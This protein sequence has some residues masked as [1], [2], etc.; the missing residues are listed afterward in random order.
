LKKKSGSSSRRKVGIFPYV[1]VIL[2]GLTVFAVGFCTALG[3][4]GNL[5]D[6]LKVLFSQTFQDEKGNKKPQKKQKKEK[7]KQGLIARSESEEKTGEAAVPE[8]IKP[9]KNIDPKQELVPEN[10]ESPEP[11]KENAKP[12]QNEETKPDTAVTESKPKINNGWKSRIPEPPKGFGIVA[13]IIDD[14]GNS[15]N[16]VEDF[17]SIDAPMTFAVLP[18]LKNSKKITAMA[19]E[20][21][22]AVVLHL[23]LENQSGI[24]PG[25]GTITTKMSRDA[26]VKDFKLNLSFVPGAEGFN[27][28]E[29]SKATEN[30]DVMDEIMKQAADRGLYF[31]DSATS[32]KS[33]GIDSAARFGVPA[34]RRNIFLD[35]EDNVDYICGQ[36]DKLT[37]KALQDG[38][39]IGIGHIRANTYTALAKMIPEMKKKGIEFVFVRDLVK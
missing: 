18:Q 9:Q 37:E 8:E 5:G 10:A 22:K 39:A 20:N 31:I 4:N 23:P 34:A 25:P 6:R 26:I 16:N 17:C 12:D 7:V 36:L 27:N 30:T 33:V 28:H 14:F 21:G 38:S 1:L 24:N 32:S 11:E 13:I 3:E 15:M 19:L 29:G 35:N 2:L